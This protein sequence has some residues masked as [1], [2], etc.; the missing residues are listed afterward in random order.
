MIT[1]LLGTMTE[2]PTRWLRAYAAPGRSERPRVCVADARSSSDAQVF[3]M[4]PERVGIGGIR[5]ALVVSQSRDARVMGA[6]LHASP[7]EKPMRIVA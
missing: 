4:T 3:W 2:P 7:M 1:R 6:G 5:V